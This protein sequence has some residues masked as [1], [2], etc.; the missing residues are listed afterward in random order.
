MPTTLSNPSIT[1]QI[2]AT[3]T[4]G[5]VPAPIGSL[6]SHAPTFSLAAGNSAGNVDRCYSASFTITTGTPLTIN[7]ASAF[8][9]LGS[10]LG[11]I[12]VTS[13]LVENDSAT[14]GQDMTIGGGANP[15]LGTYLGIAQANGGVDF[16]CN[17]NPGFTVAGGSADTLTIT[18]AAGTSVPGKITILGRSA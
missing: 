16:S 2:K 8:D 6:V 9:P 14:A 10:A 3:L 17:P 15:V 12:H 11:M 18:V 5:A 13:V 4:A 7:V 1:L